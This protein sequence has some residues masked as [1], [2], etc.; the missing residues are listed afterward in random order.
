MSESGKIFELLPIVRR[1]IGGI[2]KD[3]AN[4]AQ[5]YKYRGIDDVL[6][7]CG[8]V[9]AKHGITVVPRFSRPQPVTREKIS[10]TKDKERID[11]FTEI[12]LSLDFVAPDGSKVTVEALGEGQDFGGDKASNKAMSAAFKY[13]MLLGL[14]IPVEAGSLDDSDSDPKEAERPKS[15]PAQSVQPAKPVADPK[16]AE[17]WKY[18]QSLAIDGPNAA[19]IWGEFGQVFDRAM[20]QAY[21][22]ANK[23]ETA[24]I[25]EKWKELHSFERARDALEEQRESLL[26]YGS[27]F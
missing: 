23:L 15:E 2:G 22:F 1:E 14:V 21:A 17:F 9:L 24:L 18:C 12:V 19:S 7:H 10:L 26:G 3:Q 8:P 6:N 16:K 27:P 11:S 20:L 5:G 13:A 4:K 25:D